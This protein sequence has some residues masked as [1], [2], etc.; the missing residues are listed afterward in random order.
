MKEKKEYTLI[1]MS[2]DGEYRRDFRGSLEDCELASAN[3]GSKWYFYP[4]H[5]IVDEEDTVVSGGGFR[6]MLSDD[7]KIV[8]IIVEQTKEMQLL[9]V[10][11]VFSTVVRDD[12]HNCEPPDIYEAAVIEMLAE[13]EFMG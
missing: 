1:V 4:F 7:G 12:R 8:P 10:A 5:F 13:M 6:H 9:D 3:M 11:D 2:F